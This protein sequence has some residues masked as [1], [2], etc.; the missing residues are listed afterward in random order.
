MFTTRS[1]EVCTVMKAA[2]QVKVRCLTPESSWMLFR[3]RV[4]ENIDK[5]DPSTS[6]LAR[7]VAEKCGGLP[8]ALVTVGE[9]MAEALT[10]REWDAALKTLKSAGAL[11]FEDAQQ[12]IGLGKVRTSLK[13]SYDR[14]NDPCHQECLLYFSLFPEDC[15]IQVDE[16]IDY[17]IGEWFLKPPED[18]A[19]RPI[20]ALK[21]IRVRGQMAIEALKAACLLEDGR[22]TKISKEC[23]PDDSI[24]LKRAKPFDDIVGETAEFV[25]LH[26]M[27]R[28]MA[29]WMTHLS[30]RHHKTTFVVDPSEIPDCNEMSENWI[31]A[32][33][34]SLMSNRISKLPNWPRWVPLDTL[35]LSGC[36]NITHL[37]IRFLRFISSV[38]V[39]DLSGTK[40]RSLPEEI[41][42]A[43]ELRYLNLKGTLLESLPKEVGMLKNLRILNLDQLFQLKKIPKEAISSLRRLQSLNMNVGSVGDR[44]VWM[45]NSEEDLDTQDWKQTHNS[46]ENKNTLN[47][48]FIYRSLT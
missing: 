31:F 10:W 3:Q 8:L 1:K 40:I 36:S 21:D 41:E 37:P 38:R 15:V 2:H 23:N 35:L 34:I 6:S 16:L 46:I 18:W 39:L 28:E 7:K 44:S 33:R 11:A 17:W 14:L 26:R 12:V 32:E 20:I 24:G 5:L 27:V 29:L 45:R 22:E 30:Q 13:L 48:I 47:G 42:F 4:G 25:K 43:V 19:E 9:A